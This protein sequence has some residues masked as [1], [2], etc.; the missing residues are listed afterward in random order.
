MSI[1]L[2]LLLSN[3]AMIVVPIVLFCIASGILMVVFLGDIRELAYLLPESHSYHKTVQKDSI[4]FFKLKEKTVMNPTEL[5]SKEYLH[6]IEKDLREIKSGLIVRDNKEIFYSSPILRKV[7]AV[8]LPPFGETSSM[9]N[10]EQI[11][12]QTFAIKQYDFYLKDGSKLSLFLMRDASP[13]NKFVKTFFPILFG[14]CLLIL[15][16]TNGL[17]TYFMSKSMI[18]PIN[19]LKI[20]ARSIKNGNLEHSIQA[21][22]RDEIGQLTEDFEAMRLQLKESFEIQKQ[23]E[24]NRKE[25]IAHISHDLKTP[26]T[27]IKGYIEGIRDGVADTPDKRAKYIQTIYT[28]AV[29]LDHLIDELFLFSKLDLRKAPFHFEV[30]DLKNYLE[31]YIEELSFDLKKM[32]VNIHFQ[33]QPEG[34]YLVQ[35]D[36][37]KIKRVLSNIVDNSL[38]YMDKDVKK[39]EIS[40]TSTIEKV[41]L[42][43]S[44]N[45]PGIPEDSLPFIFNQFYRA[46]QSRNKLTGGSG[47]GLSIARMI[48]EEHQ[49]TI[50]VENKLSAGTKITITLPHTICPEVTSS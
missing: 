37:E 29:D 26:I 25:L 16:V 19:R 32:N 49:G 23:Y 4:L 47:L 34:D 41:E 14:L 44:D 5:M 15:I 27:S 48:V 42:I 7:K 38:K 17:L 43:I 40:L 39:L 11:G 20:A 8:D 6:S 30:V 24:E 50:Q 31:D 33:I 9:R 35:T 22:R 1:K 10:L 28:K 13:W 12:T 21:I 46:E 18:K 36:R 45:G 2:R 3:I